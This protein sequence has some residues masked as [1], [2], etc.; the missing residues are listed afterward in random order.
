MTTEE[1]CGNCKFYD[2]DEHCN[3]YPPVVNTNWAGEVA[4]QVAG[5]VEFHRRDKTLRPDVGD[6]DWCGE[7]V[8]T[9]SCNPELLSTQGLGVRARKVC[10]RMGVKTV[11]ELAEKTESDI[12]SQRNAGEWTV[13]DINA[14]LA[15]FGL[16]LRSDKKDEK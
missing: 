9:A 15:R 7:W 12:T 6:Y 16:E 11:G 2:G 8:K 13:A 10:V 1:N 3:R 5:A 4:C 14:L